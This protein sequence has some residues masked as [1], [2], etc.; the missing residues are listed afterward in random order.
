MARP[1]PPSHFLD[2]TEAPRAE[3]VFLETGPQPLY[4]GLDW[5]LNYTSSTTLSYGTVGTRCVKLTL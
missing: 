1:P 3:K 2:Q 5:A 4:L